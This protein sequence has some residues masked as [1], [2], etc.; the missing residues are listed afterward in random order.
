M[1]RS[2]IGI[3]CAHACGRSFAGLCFSQSPG[4]TRYTHASP[5]DQTF[6]AVRSPWH[7]RPRGA[8]AHWTAATC[9]LQSQGFASLQQ[10]RWR[11]FFPPVNY[12]CGMLQRR[13]LPRST[14]RSMGVCSCRNELSVRAAHQRSCR[15]I[16]SNFSLHRSPRTS[17]QPWPSWLLIQL[18]RRGFPARNPELPSR[19]ARHD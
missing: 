16:R 5:D 17:I 19:T 3:S 7:A 10:V 1:R 15:P 8:G 6:V 9:M 14:H 12:R 18:S 4:F 2:A 11:R 13:L